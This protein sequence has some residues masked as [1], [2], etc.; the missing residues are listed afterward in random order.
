MYLSSRL[1][2]NVRDVMNYKILSKFVVRSPT[3]LPN[4]KY[5]K[6]IPQTLYKLQRTFEYGKTVML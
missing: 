4:G 3:A 2:Q 5:P 6:N 1:L